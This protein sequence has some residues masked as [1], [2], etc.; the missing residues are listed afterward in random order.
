MKKI[1]FCD[2]HVTQN[3][4]KH[5]EKCMFMCPKSSGN[6]KLKVDATFFD[7]I[8]VKIDSWIRIL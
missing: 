1:F 3:D 6:S 7:I 8:F 5:P 4:V 2:F